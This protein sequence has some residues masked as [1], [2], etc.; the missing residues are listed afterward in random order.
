V[1]ATSPIGVILD[2]DGLM[3]DTERVA[4]RAWL[5]AAETNK[6]NLPEAVYRGLIGLDEKGCRAHLRSH[7]WNADDIDVLLRSA[8]TRYLELLKNDG[9]PTKPGLFELLDFLDAHN[10][11]RAVATST[12]TAP[13]RKKLKKVGVLDRLDAV[14]G[15]DQVTAGKPA[16]DIY[17]RAAEVVG[18]QPADCVALEDSQN[19]S[20]AALAAGMKVILVPD[21]CFVDEQTRTRVFA[22]VDSLAEATRTIRA[23]L[24]FDHLDCRTGLKREP[25]APR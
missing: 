7:A 11:P 15:G 14:I 2:M 6:L 22:T 21:L 12:L 3:L 10:I 8:W 17:L 16:P 13:A 4:M 18:R 1:N 20:R 19:G 25:S 23:L 5:G 9:V 24:A